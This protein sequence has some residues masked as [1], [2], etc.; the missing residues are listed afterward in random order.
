MRTILKTFVRGGIPVI[1]PISF[2]PE[3]QPAGNRPLQLKRVLLGAV[4]TAVCASAIALGILKKGMLVFSTD[5]MG[6]L[7]VIVPLFGAG[8]V[9]AMLRIRSGNLRILLQPL[10]VFVAVITGTPLGHD[11]VVTSL[12]KVLRD[13]MRKGLP[14]AKEREIVAVA[15]LAAGVAALFGTPLAA[16]F[17]VVELLLTELTLTS[18]LPV[19][20]GVAIGG[21]LHYLYDEWALMS[22][23]SADVPSLL[24]YLVMGLF[25]GL[26]ATLAERV[27]AGLRFLFEK[28]PAN[29][30]WL[31]LVVAA[32][33][34]GISIFYIPEL[35]GAPFEDIDKL[36]DG[37]VTLS[38][39]VILGLIKLVLAMLSIAAGVPG[40]SMLPLMTSG[41]A[42]GMLLIL[43]IQWAMP[44]LHLDMMIGVLAGMAAMLAGGLRIL[45]AAVLLIIELTHEPDL[46]GPVIC[47]SAA[48][49]L[50]VFLLAR[51]KGVPREAD[52]KASMN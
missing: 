13:G 22:V 51:K 35:A 8:L 46:L 39:L 43:L 12:G 19:V 1:S 23:A 40:G 30:S 52:I 9:I 14:Q 32:L 45:P 36:F 2:L 5:K 42:L 3:R 17:L 15:G 10:M 26:F 31:T 33:V 41:G 6:P 21:G 7:T 16:L 47:A 27:Q 4:V 34:I 44:S 37:H 49:Y 50:V 11:G 20:L 18:I 38:F 48:S 24:G 25:I 29:R 28:I